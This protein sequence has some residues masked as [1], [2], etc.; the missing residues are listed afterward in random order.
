MF[1][2]IQL[3]SYLIAPLGTSKKYVF[4]LFSMFLKGKVTLN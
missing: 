3:N 2:Y 1:Y 4:I